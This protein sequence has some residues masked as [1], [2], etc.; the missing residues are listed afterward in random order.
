MLV[1][2][3][4]KTQLQMAISDCFT[5]A[6]KQ[7]FKATLV[8]KSQKGDETAEK[9]A[10]SF[11]NNLAEPLASRL[12]DC[13]DYYIKS[14]TIQGTIMTAGSPAAQTAVIMPSTYITKGVVPNTF[15][16]V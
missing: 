8:E 10:Q 1:P 3:L 15:K 9:F 2:S 6:C 14:A 12:T 4:L 7:A 11:V 13:I 5:V 16:I